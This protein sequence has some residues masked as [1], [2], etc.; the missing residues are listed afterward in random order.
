MK[1]IQFG[2]MQFPQL[3]IFSNHLAIFLVNM[4]K[5]T[6]SGITSINITLPNFDIYLAISEKYFDFQYSHIPQI[7]FFQ[8]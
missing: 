8:L 3:Y 6:S 7:S 4:L 5:I 2:I 1:F